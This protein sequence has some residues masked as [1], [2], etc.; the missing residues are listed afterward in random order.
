VPEELCTDNSTFLSA[1]FREHA[2]NWGFRHITS[3]PTYNQANGC[4][5]AAIRRAKTLMTEAAEAGVDRFSLYWT[6][7]NR[8][9]IYSYR[10]RR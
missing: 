8:Q 7:V 2:D 10:R 4:A 3:S 1:E 9:N 6:S 5:E